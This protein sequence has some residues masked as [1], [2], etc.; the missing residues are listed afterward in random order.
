MYNNLCKF[1]FNDDFLQKMHTFSEKLLTLNWITLNQHC[2][3]FQPLLTNIYG[4]ISWQWVCKKQKYTFIYK[5]HYCNIDTSIWLCITWSNYLLKCSSHMLKASGIIA[6]Q[7]IPWNKKQKQSQE[8]VSHQQQNQ[9]SLQVILIWFQTKFNICVCNKQ[10]TLS[11]FQNHD[12]GMN[13]SLSVLTVP[14]L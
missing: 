6:Y 13:I 1:N 5:L 14:R 10:T 3:S 9:F 12:I 7:I 11:Y 4:I 8:F 2:F